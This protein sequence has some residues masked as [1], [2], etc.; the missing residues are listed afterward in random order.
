MSDEDLSNM[1]AEVDVDGNG[2]IGF[3]E[4]VQLFK[5]TSGGRGEKD[6][7]KST[8]PA[9]ERKD[10]SFFDNAKLYIQFGRGLR[11]V[12]WLYSERKMILL[13]CSHVVASLIIWSH[14]AMIRYEQQEGSVPEDASRYAAKRI[15]P[16]FLYGGKHCSKS[17]SLLC[18]I[19][20]TR[21]LT[22]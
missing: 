20:N 21:S 4:F 6:E 17:L 14:Y 10:S 12:T 16:P 8:T 18:F 13:A 1:V 19:P 15:V 7:G 3:D 5:G 2:E 11:F 22:P 9:Y